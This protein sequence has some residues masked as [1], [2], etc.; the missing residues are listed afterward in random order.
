MNER[1]RMTE[2]CIREKIQFL[3]DDA[4][5]VELTTGFERW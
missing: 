4:L 3:R 2:L 5:S 1:L